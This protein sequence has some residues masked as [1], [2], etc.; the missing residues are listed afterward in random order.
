[1]NKKMKISMRTLFVFSIIFFFLSGLSVSSAESVNERVFVYTDKD[2]YVVG[3]DVWM[4]FCV[5]TPD[6]APSLLSKVGYIEISDTQKPYLQ[7]KLALKDGTGSGK[8]RISEDIPSGIYELSGYTRFMRNEDAKVVF[9]RKIAIINPAQKLDPK[10]AKLAEKITSPARS[11]VMRNDIG[12]KTDKNTYQGREKINLSIENLSQGLSELVVSVRRNDSFTLMESPD[13]QAW[14]KQT[15]QVSSTISDEWLPEYEGHIITGKF[16]GELASDISASLSVVGDKICYIPGQ[17]ASGRGVASFYTGEIY[18]PQQIV[19]SAFNYSL[20]E[21]PNQIAILS[22][23]ANYVPEHL[24]ELQISPDSS[25]LADRYLGAQLTEDSV[26][27]HTASE[28]AY[29][30]PDYN[31]D[32]NQYTRFP[33]L[34][35]TI[36]EF[37]YTVKIGK[38]ND[39]RKFRV[40]SNEANSFASLNTLVLLDGVPVFDQEQLISYNPYLL[41]KIEIFDGR[42]AF[43][44]KIFDCIL[45]FTS[46]K[47]DLPAYQLGPGSLLFKYDFPSLPVPFMMP[48]YSTEEAR[49]SRKPDFRHTLYWNPSVKVDAGKS[50]ELPF[51]TSDLKGNFEVLV[52]GITSEGKFVSGKSYFEVK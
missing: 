23:Y 36:I 50:T 43:G 28:S 10:R 33:T 44:D 38:V 21:V 40:F 25:S 6:L 31:Y 4:K 17:I 37:V 26:F 11:S 13:N 20:K 39:V 49:K 35:E 48:D 51:F 12:V 14:L 32:M 42:Y 24:P 47:K 45:F 8:I 46:H 18:G 3:E 27:P 34:N 5:M 30:T 52:E 16:V 22:P 29:Y 9:K 1:M 15:K 41:R 19:T 7:L 2:C